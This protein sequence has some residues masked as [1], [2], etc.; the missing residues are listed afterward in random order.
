MIQGNIMLY[1][2]DETVYRIKN[3]T[4]KICRVHLRFIMLI[5]LIEM[6]AE[7]IEAGCVYMKCYRHENKIF[8]EVTKYLKIRIVC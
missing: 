6:I 4:Y 1:Q 7:L 5:I 3:L 8:P 2:T